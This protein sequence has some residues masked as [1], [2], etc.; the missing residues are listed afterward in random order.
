MTSSFPET[1]AV[2]ARHIAAVKAH[3]VEGVLSNFADDAVVFTPDGVLRGREA[4]RKDTEAFFAN[5][6]PDLVDRLEFVRKDVEG[7][8][9]Y[10]IWK[11]EP[12]VTLA[13]ESFVIRGGKIMTQTFALLA[14][15]VSAG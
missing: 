10:L 2:L 3:D 8:V 11:A 9:A 5:S 13:T 1:A 15:T 4:I 7:D 12:F 14:G 6:P